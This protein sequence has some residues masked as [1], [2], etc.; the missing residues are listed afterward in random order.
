MIALHLP[1][2]HVN[3]YMF[4]VIHRWDAPGHPSN[5]RYRPIPPF[6]KV[7]Q[8]KWVLLIIQIRAE[9]VELWA[10]WSTRGLINNEV[11]G[12][13]HNAEP[14]SCVRQ[15]PFRDP[16]AVLQQRYRPLEPTLRVATS[17]TDLE[18]AREEIHRREWRERIVDHPWVF[19]LCWRGECPRFPLPVNLSI[20][21]LVSILIVCPFLWVQLAIT[22]ELC[23]N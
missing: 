8:E 1:A 17:I 14:L 15:G 19:P 10:T 5:Q 18:E 4:A 23:R 7:Y 20:L 6:V 16:A 22:M 2:S 12:L 13:R 21:S 11:G 9:F 3:L